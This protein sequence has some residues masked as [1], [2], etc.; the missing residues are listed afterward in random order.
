M[1]PRCMWATDTTPAIVDGDDPATAD[2]FFTAAP[3]PN[4]TI[5]RIVDF[6][7]DTE[8][9][10]EA[11]AKFLA[12]IVPDQTTNRRATATSSFTPPPPSTTPS[13]S[14]ARSGR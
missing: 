11:M 1:S 9:D 7:P 4:G 10:T 14:T 6:P 2:R 3:A 8:Y 13:S 5:L 12:T